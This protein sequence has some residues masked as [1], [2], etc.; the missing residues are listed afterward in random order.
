MLGSQHKTGC[1]CLVWAGL[2]IDRKGFAHQSGSR[3]NGNPNARPPFSTYSFTHA[4]QRLGGWKPE[5]TAYWSHPNTATFA[6]RCAT[7]NFVPA[8]PTQTWSG[9]I[10][11]ENC[12][13]IS[14]SDLDPEYRK[15]GNLVNKTNMKAADHSIYDAD[16]GIERT[17]FPHSRQP[18]DV[19]IALALELRSSQTR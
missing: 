3:A 4:I 5:S 17:R 18:A 6:H 8:L 16:C 11:P 15:C 2:H 9:R 7:V 10:N 19:I 14:C 12:R 13:K 1:R